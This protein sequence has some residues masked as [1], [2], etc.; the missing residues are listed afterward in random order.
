MH[1]EADRVFIA[2]R[3]DM[4]ESSSIEEIGCICPRTTDYTTSIDPGSRVI[5]SGQSKECELNGKLAEALWW[6]KDAKCW[7]CR[8]FA[9]NR[10]VKLP[11]NVL[12]IAE[13]CPA[14]GS[15]TRCPCWPAGRGVYP[16]SLGCRCC[17]KQ[18][19][20]E[21]ADA[22]GGV[23]VGWPY[24]H[25][26]VHLPFDWN[27]TSL[28]GVLF[29]LRHS[30]EHY[31]HFNDMRVVKAVNRDDVKFDNY[32]SSMHAFI[33]HDPQ[34]DGNRLR[35]RAER[36]KVLCRHARDARAARPLLFVRFVHESW[37]FEHIDELYS[38]LRLWAGPQI[39]L[40]IVCMKQVSKGQERLYRH[41]RFPRVLFYLVAFVAVMEFDPIIQ[42][43]RFAVYDEAGLLNCPTILPEELP[44]HKFRD[45]Y[46]TS[47]EL[48]TE[49][50]WLTNLKGKDPAF[51]PDCPKAQKPGS[52]VAAQQLGEAILAGDFQRVA[53]SIR[54]GSMRA[55]VGTD[56]NCWD[57][58][59]RRPLHFAGEA[60]QRFKRPTCNIV[61]IVGTLLLARIRGATTLQRS[62]P[63]STRGAAGPHGRSWRSWRPPCWRRAWT[64]RPSSPPWRCWA[65][66][67][68]AA[69]RGSWTSRPCGPWARPSSCGGTRPRTARPSSRSSRTSS[70]ASSG[71]R[72]SSGRRR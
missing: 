64:R 32:Y 24:F 29:F 59:G 44:F 39:R 27:L 51:Y 57:T 22:G 6:D 49:G 2:D 37:E 66:S 42:A 31:F 25:G 38:L 20:L 60:E 71:C 46:T 47:S 10:L 5:I 30:F 55:S 48:C 65:G 33:H 41:R 11:V 9:I 67:P 15:L 14:G 61:K 18:G 45:P 68:A 35:H 50:D 23:G 40:C 13:C 53:E 34:K 17:V 70:W 72:R 4:F 19:I 58:Q 52:R 3:W 8:V 63:W 28:N 1:A 12:H 62:P 43:C 56:P 54:S 69:L 26:M 21:C 36:F 7:D 16:V